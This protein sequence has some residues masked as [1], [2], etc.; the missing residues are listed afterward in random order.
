LRLPVYATLPND[1]KGVHRAI[2]LG[3]PVDGSSELGKRFRQL[4]ES[5][6]GASE[7]QPAGRQRFVEYFTLAP[8]RYTLLPTKDGPRA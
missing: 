2:A 6:L 7:P 1:Y 3:K 4:G 8:A 5:L